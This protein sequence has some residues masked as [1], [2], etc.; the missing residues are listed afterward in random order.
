MAVCQFA[1]MSDAREQTL[2]DLVRS[3]LAMMAALAAV[4]ELSLPDG[5]IAAGF[6][7]NRVWDHLHGYAKSTP[8]NDIDVVYFD[9]ACLDEAVEKRFEAALHQRLAGLPWSVKNQARMAAINGDQ[10]YRDTADAL[11]HWCETPTPIGL[12]LIEEGGLQML[13][14]LGLEDLFALTVRPTPFAREHPPKLAQYK[15]RMARKNWPGLWPGI[16]V[17]EL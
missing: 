10:P 7:R 5:W 2:I 6:V 9:S 11:E 13:A 4:R 16:R 12:R 1:G 8:L 15:E 14:P 3:D 17:L